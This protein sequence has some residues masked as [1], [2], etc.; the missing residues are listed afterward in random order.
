ME[1]DW[2][3]GTTYKESRIPLSRELFPSEFLDHVLWWNGL[4]WLQMPSLVW[5]QQSIVPEIET[6]CSGEISLHMIASEKIPIIPIDRYSSFV[7][8]KR[9]TAWV[10]RFT[11]NCHTKKASNT[12]LSPSFTTAELRAAEIYWLS[13]IQ[14]DHFAEELKAIKQNQEIRDSS[15]LLSLH[16]F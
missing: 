10:L 12:Q 9:S 16:P 11:H 3:A 8:L 6:E 15:S 1:L 13:V 14:Q 5:P 4:A 7:R 2:I